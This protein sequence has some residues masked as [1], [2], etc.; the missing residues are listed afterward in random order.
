MRDTKT[1][2]NHWFTGSWL[3]KGTPENHVYGSP[4][5][6]VGQWCSST[7]KERTIKTV[8]KMTLRLFDIY[9]SL[10]FIMFEN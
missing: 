6:N 4:P 3:G 1:N 2:D 5:H 8:L 7:T 9:I 10:G